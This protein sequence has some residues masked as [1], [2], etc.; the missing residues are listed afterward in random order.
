MEKSVESWR[1]LLWSVITEDC[2][3]LVRMAGCLLSPRIA[4]CCCSCGVKPS[5]SRKCDLHILLK[6]PC[7]CFLQLMTLHF[8]GLFSIKKGGSGGRRRNIRK[9][10]TWIWT[11][12]YVFAA[13]KD[14]LCSMLL[15]HALRLDYTIASLHSTY[16]ALVFQ[17]FL[18]LL[19]KFRW[20]L[21]R[22]FGTVHHGQNLGNAFW[23]IG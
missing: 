19:S 2:L 21:R 20:I 13:F 10:W 15:A 7:A 1:E 5:Y 8:R 4:F 11:G 12:T 17:N 3:R 6:L 9:E 23:L 18:M 14:L 22:Q 16:A